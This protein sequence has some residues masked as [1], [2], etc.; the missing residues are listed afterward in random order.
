MCLLWRFN[1]MPLNIFYIFMTLS[2]GFVWIVWQV[3]H[4]G[5]FTCIARYQTIK[6]TWRTCKEGLLTHFK[7]VRLTHFLCSNRILSRARKSTKV[8]Q[9]T[10][11]DPTW[12]VINSFLGLSI[13]KTKTCDLWILK[14]WF[15]VAQLVEM[16]ISDKTCVVVTGL[17]LV[18]LCSSTPELTLMCVTDRVTLTWAQWKHVRGTLSEHKESRGWWVH[19]WFINLFY[20]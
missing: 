4:S 11:R 1:S 15:K 10:P 7:G 20:D 8:N 13:Y 14:E 19:T 5:N 17:V 16:G 12:W 18:L 9:T 6:V 2:T 3:A